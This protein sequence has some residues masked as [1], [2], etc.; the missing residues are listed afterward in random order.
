MDEVFD[1]DRV[2]DLV[3]PLGGPY[4]P[5]AVVQAATTVAELVRRLNHATFHPMALRYPSQLYRVVGGLRAGVYGLDQTLRQLAA[6]LDGWAADPSVGHDH[7]HDPAATCADASERLHRAA[8]ALVAVTR[9]LDT[10]YEATS[11]LSLD[12]PEH[13]V[14]RAF[15]PAAVSSPATPPSPQQQPPPRSSPGRAR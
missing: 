6:R 11:H 9:P 15:P 7:G 8:V 12:E 14:R 1:V 5:E 10:A 2:A 3:L 13:T 4:D